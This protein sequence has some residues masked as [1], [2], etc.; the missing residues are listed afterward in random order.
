MSQ[1]AGSVH[2]TDVR[3]PTSRTDEALVRASRSDP[4]AFDELF[5][6]HAAR[7]DAWFRARIVD[8]EV[9]ADL[10][11]ETFAQ[12]LV[13]VTRFRGARTGSA[14]AWLNGIARNLLLQYYRRDRVA[15]R[16]RAKLAMLNETVAPDVTDAID[17]AVDARTAAGKL[18]AAIV[19]LPDD[20]QLALQLR[21]L[22]RRSYDDVASLLGCTK[23]A[24]RMKVSRGLRS[25]DAAIRGVEG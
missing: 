3:S 18:A 24:A 22:D 17:D 8:R 12:A 15:S 9:A 14:A 25:L 20:Q 23:T 5:R 6:R 21:V 7:I 2:V 4:D 16:A 19:T 1:D 11:A 10:V 13:S